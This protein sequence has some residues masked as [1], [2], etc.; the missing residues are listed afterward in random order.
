M[1]K[2][3]MSRPAKFR[4]V[5]IQIPKEEFEVTAEDLIV[6][7]RKEAMLTVRLQVAGAEHPHKLLEPKTVK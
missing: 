3:H 4:G 1:V 5:S 6:F 7:F 2:T